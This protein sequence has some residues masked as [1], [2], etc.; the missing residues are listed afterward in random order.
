MPTRTVRQWADLGFDFAVGHLA[1]FGRDPLA[2]LHRCVGVHKQRK[3]LAGVL[4]MYSEQL[5]GL[6]RLLG[7]L[8][9]DSTAIGVPSNF[10]KKCWN[11]G[12]PLWP[13]ISITLRKVQKNS[14]FCG[15]SCIHMF[16][17]GIL[18]SWA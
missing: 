4:G 7:L 10:A 11:F 17:G 8:V 3:Q 6:D 13:L 5:I 1:F 2:H 14:K 9:L 18:E 16:G 15:G 12:K